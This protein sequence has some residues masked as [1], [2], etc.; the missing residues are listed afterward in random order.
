MAPESKQAKYQGEPPLAPI[1]RKSMKSGLVAGGAV[2]ENERPET[3]VLEAVNFHFDT[4]GSAILRKGMTAVGNN[5]ALGNILGLYQ[6]IDTVNV[7]ANNQLIAGAGTSVYYKNG[8]T[9]SAIRTGLT[10]GSKQRYVTFLN[11]IFMV[12]GT[13]ATAIWDGVVSD[14]F[15]TSGNASGAPTGQFIEVFQARVWILGNA[16]YPSRLFY[17]SVPSAVTTP[18][19]TWNTDVTTGTWIDI[20][21]QD[22]D[23]PT[24]L[25]RFRNTLLIFKTNRLYRL[26]GIGQVDADPWYAVG[27]SSQESVIETK[28][29]VFFHHSSGFYQYN[30]YGIV[31]EISLPVIDYVRAIPAS[32]YPNVAGWLEPDND[33]VVWAV[34]TI[35]VTTPWGSG[36]NKGTTYT[37]CEMRYTISSQTWTVYSRATKITTSIRRQPFYVDT[38]QQALCGD[39]T[40]NVAEINTG[41]QDLN[42]VGIANQPINYS[43]IHRWENLDGLLSTRLT[44]NVINFSHK[45]GAGSKV[46]Y[47]TDEQD[48]DDLS[49]WVQKVG[50][51]ELKDKNTGYESADIKGRKFRIRISGT[52]TGQPFTYDGYE[53]L[54]AQAEFYNFS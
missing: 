48:Q 54:D 37:N 49:N 47:Q 18:V 20:S 7:P 32:A 1:D 53:I 11:F 14:G 51:G 13:E 21:P 34:G 16:T 3:S 24:A 6:F 50:D 38:Y 2:S 39:N 19:V 10:A 36:G 40:G 23:F 8:G 9:W 52:S 35:T 43:L 26:F 27:T 29:G 4:I 5:L 15:V 33:H 42:T 12:N 30:I 41:T 17:T 44:V 22:G 45:G 28:T 31:E 25:Q 46:A